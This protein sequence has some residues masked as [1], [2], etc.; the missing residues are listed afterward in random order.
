MFC[1]SSKIIKCPSTR[2]WD[3]GMPGSSKGEPSGR[4]CFNTCLGRFQPWKTAPEDTRSFP[5]HWERALDAFG[6]KGSSNATHCDVRTW[7]PWESM[8][9]QKKRIERIDGSH[10][11]QQL[12]CIFLVWPR[13]RKSHRTWAFTTV[14][15]KTCAKFC[16]NR[17]FFLFFSRLK[18]SR[19]H[20]VR[21]QNTGKPV[22]HEGW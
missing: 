9:K 7:N 14:F 1:L 22:D 6:Q 15:C 18:W 20:W 2:A 16:K 21:C 17:M 11:G 10:T 4:C 8:G 3:E 12:P 13:K 19:I 5:R